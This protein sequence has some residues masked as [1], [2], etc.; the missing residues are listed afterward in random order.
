MLAD[1]SGHVGRA[2]ELW[3]PEP[4][5]PGQQVAILARVVGR[6]LRYEAVPDA[7]AR[8]DMAGTTPAPLID[9]FFRFYSEGEFDDSRVVGTVQG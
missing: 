4:L 9:A 5:T 6:P 7:Q 1:P 3:G 2:Y 8:A